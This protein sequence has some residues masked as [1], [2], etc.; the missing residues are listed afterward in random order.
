MKE[1]CIFGDLET[2]KRLGVTAESLRTLMR[3]AIGKTIFGLCCEYNHKH[4]IYLYFDVTEF[5]NV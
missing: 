3:E 1:A 4:C 5:L 2:I